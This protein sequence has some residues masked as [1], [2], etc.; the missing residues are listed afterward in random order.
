MSIGNKALW[1]GIVVICILFTG[2]GKDPLTSSEGT[3]LIIE[4]SQLEVE[5]ENIESEPITNETMGLEEIIEMPPKETQPE[6]TQSQETQMEEIQPEETVGLE[7]PQSTEAEMTEI[8]GNEI[9]MEGIDASAEN[10]GK[11]YVVNEDGTY[12]FERKIYKYKMAVTSKSGTIYIVL[13]NNPD[14]KYEDIEKSFIASTGIG[15]WWHTV[16]IGIKVPEE[17]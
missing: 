4:T 17:E 7:T 6:E 15:I 16:I 5:E 12:T 3:S 14:L 8:V 1:S 2:C 10:L 11:Q 9:G 13:T